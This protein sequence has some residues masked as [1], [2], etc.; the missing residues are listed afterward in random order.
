MRMQLSFLFRIACSALLAFCLALWSFHVLFSK[1]MVG[2]T[3]LAKRWVSYTLELLLVQTV[4]IWLCGFLQKREDIQA[5]F[6]TS[7]GACST[8][9]EA[10]LSASNFDYFH[11]SCTN[12]SSL[13]TFDYF[14][15]DRERLLV[16]GHLFVGTTLLMQYRR[17]FRLR[18][19]C[20]SF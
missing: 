20:Y 9:R 2:P 4:W 10:R 14:H 7:F 13:S 18:S 19:A 6:Q 12:C 15:G 8:L 3:L 1:N 5:L 11:C 16:V 17:F